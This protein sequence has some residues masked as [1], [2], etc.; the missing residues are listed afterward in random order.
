[1]TEKELNKLANLISQKVID[2]LESKQQDWDIEFYSDLQHFVPNGEAKIEVDD[3]EQSLLADLDKLKS[4][5]SEYMKTEQYEKCSEIE[6]QI[7]YTKYKLRN[8]K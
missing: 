2:S 4:L 8:L 1:M 6:N 7:T 5:L 3:E